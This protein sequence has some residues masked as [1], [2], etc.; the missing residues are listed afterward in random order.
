MANCD[1]YK[2][3]ELRGLLP[4]ASQLHV[5]LWDKDSFVFDDLI[6]ETVIDLENRFFSKRWRNLPYK[7]IE[8][9]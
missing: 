7:P 8:S 5:Q 6:G 3:Y 1:I 9:R 4:G 2:M